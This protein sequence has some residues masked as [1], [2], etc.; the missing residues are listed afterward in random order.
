MQID[1]IISLSAAHRGG[2][3]AWTYD[4]R[5]AFANDPGSLL[6]VDGPTNAAKSDRGPA[7]WM[8]EDPASWCDYAADYTT[9][10]R[11]YGLAVSADDRQMLVDVLTACA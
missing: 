2:A 6:A 9:I 7:D 5:V 10:A 8:P 1:H 11:T 4:E 3:W